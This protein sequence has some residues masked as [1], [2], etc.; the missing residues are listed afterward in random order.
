M[1]KYGHIGSCYLH[2][3]IQI[4]AS[5]LEITRVCISKLETFIKACITT[6]NPT[7]SLLKPP[8]LSAEVGVPWRSRGVE[9]R[10][11]DKG[12]EGEIHVCVVSACLWC[13][14][15]VTFGVNLS[16]SAPRRTFIS[17]A[18]ASGGRCVPFTATVS[19][20]PGV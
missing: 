16:P 8:R 5:S 17:G 13:R 9:R 3:T 20:H 10:G 11:M 7:T 1:L 15:L 2:T 12:T 14:H 4:V 6:T 18:S 19:P